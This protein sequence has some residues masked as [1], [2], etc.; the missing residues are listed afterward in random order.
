[1]YNCIKLLGKVHKPPSNYHQIDNVTS[2]LSIVTMSPLNYQNIV[3]IPSNDETTLNKNFFKK[4]TKISRE[5]HKTK[6]KN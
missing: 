3:N 2:K 1:V 5:K 6:K 4:N